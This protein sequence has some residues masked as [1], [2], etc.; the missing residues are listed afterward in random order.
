LATLKDFFQW[1][2]DCNARLAEM[3]R[4]LLLA[5][6]EYENLDRKLGE[7]IFSEDLLA[8]MRESI[9]T[10]R[11]VTWVFAGSHAIVELTHAPWSSYLVSARTLEVPPFTEAETRRLLTEPL[12]YSSLWR[13]D[14]SKRPRFSPDFWGDNGIERIHTEAGGWPHLVQL[15]AE[16]VVDL[17]NDQG[18][19][20]ADQTLLEQAIAKAVVAGDTV[21]RQLMQPE[22]A[23]PGEW[24][25]LRRFRSRDIQP[26]PDDEAVYQALR[27]R[28]LVVEEGGQW[29]L[30]VPLMQRWLRE[31]G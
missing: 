23:A 20:R 6:D 24:E 15:L 5:I 30:R 18:L 9:Q 19:S 1:L 2:S 4:R 13:D 22:D 3:D 25:Y 21:L 8:T 11:Q 7:G 16:T 27:H 31:R 29:R 14:D 26:P 28:L 17:C 12:R 10:H